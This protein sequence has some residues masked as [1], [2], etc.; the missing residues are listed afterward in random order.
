M[1]ALKQLGKGQPTSLPSIVAFTLFLIMLQSGGD[2]L[3]QPLY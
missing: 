3:S 2:F 1:L